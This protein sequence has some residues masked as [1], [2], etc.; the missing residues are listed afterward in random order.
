M[1]YQQSTKGDIVLWAIRYV[2]RPKTQEIIL[3]NKI[4][5]S[6][7]ELNGEFFKMKIG[8]KDWKSTKIIE[9]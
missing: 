8:L 2:E 3:D 5:L 7:R 4:Q 9:S 6:R 1:R